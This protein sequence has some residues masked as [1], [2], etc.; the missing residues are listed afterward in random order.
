MDLLIAR[1]AL[2]HG[3]ALR[4]MDKPFEPVRGGRPGGECPAAGMPVQ[5]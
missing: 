3:I 4:T 1:L 5:G 2:K